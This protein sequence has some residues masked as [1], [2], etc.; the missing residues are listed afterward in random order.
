MPKNRNFDDHVRL[1][2]TWLEKA[3]EKYFG[4]MLVKVAS[5]YDTEFYEETIY[6]IEG[7]VHDGKYRTLIFWN[8]IYY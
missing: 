5:W 6:V 7:T 3:T 8:T 1:Y 2:N 4:D